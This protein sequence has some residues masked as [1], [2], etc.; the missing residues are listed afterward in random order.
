MKA[1]SAQHPKMDARRH[2]LDWLR[3]GAFLILILYHIGMF[4]VPWGWHVKSGHAPVQALELPMKLLSPWRIPLLFFISGVAL[5]FALDKGAQLALMRRRIWVLFLPLVFGMYIICAPQAWFELVENG[6]WD[7]S[8]WGFYAHY[9]DWPWSSPTD[10]P[11]ITPTW[12]HLW[13]VLYLLIFTLVLATISW[14]SRRRVEAVL[15]PLAVT[16]LVMIAAPFVQTAFLFLFYES[17]G[18]SQTLYGDWYNLCT[19]F[20]TMAFGF[21]VSKQELFWTRLHNLRGVMFGTA[22][23]LAICLAVFHHN[24]TARPV[25]QLTS[26]FFGWMMIWAILGWGQVLRDKASP[27]LEY[28]SRAIFTYYILHQTIIIWVGVPLSKLGLPLAVEATILIISTGF[29]CWAG[30]EFGARRLGRAGVLLGARAR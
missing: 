5:R 11:I 20:C 30:Y 9:I 22:I 29:I 17:V 13:Y 6:T 18:A 24:E 12:N 15:S 26:I 16:A 14:L 1:R 7:G 8:F 21:L 23:I 28:L 4:Y 27:V 19:S 25:S 10:W 2:D 3:I